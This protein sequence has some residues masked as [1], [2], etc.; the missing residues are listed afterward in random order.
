[1]FP[2]LSGMHGSCPFIRPV[3]VLAILLAH[4]SVHAG[5]VLHAQVHLWADTY[6][7]GLV[8]GSFSLGD[9]NAGFGVIPMPVPPGSTILKA[10]L[11]ASDV[12]GGA[13]A[14]LNFTLNG[15]PYAFGPSTA[16][17]SYGSV[18]GQITLHTLDL[19]D[20][21]DPGVTSHALNVPAT[22]FREFY[23]LIEYELPG[24]QP[25]HVDLFFSDRDSELTIDYTLNSTWP[26]LTAGGI[27]FGTMGGYAQDYWN[28][29]EFVR[30]N[31]VELGRFYGPDFNAVPGNTFGAAAS[32]HFTNG[33]FEGIG[34]DDPDQAIDGG[35]VLTDLSGLVANG[36]TSFHVEYEHCPTFM[37]AA[38]RD[39]HVN[40]MVLAYTSDI[41]LFPLALGPDTTLCTGDSLVLDATVPGA[42]GYLWQ[43]GSTAPTFT[44]HEAGT[45]HV[46]VI[47][48]DCTWEPDTIVVGM[49]PLSGVDLGGD[50]E[51]C[52]GEEV[53]LSVPP[54]DGATYTWG[55]GHTGP[56]REVTEAGTYVLTAAI[57]TCSYT[58][59]VRITVAP[60]LFGVELPNVFSPNGDPSNPYFTPIVMHGV[61]DVRISVF[62]RWGQELFTSL[63]PGFRWDGRSPAGNPVPDGTYFWVL[64]YVRTSGPQEQQRLHGTVTL[65][66]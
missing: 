22:T 44:M 61:R 63:D 56:W 25:V 37:P 4:L 29:C 45:Y 49:H 57:A 33:L 13:G 42:S 47:H 2:V 59:S 32:F 27:A 5:G 19:T 50:R 51:I 40:L 16:G 3:R 46:Q 66:R 1:M 9:Q 34:D 24:A 31:G 48:P 64:E 58:D 18:Y 12:G 30:V 23:F 21:L 10:H 54:V 52:L 14:T 7:G 11:F 28:D 41:C 60:C 26:M 39:N 62:N 53:V 15:V 20:D 8:T 17:P 55:D 36:A 6:N 65:L 43:D 35:D 38:Q